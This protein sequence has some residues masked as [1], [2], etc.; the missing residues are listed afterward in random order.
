MTFWTFAFISLARPNQTLK[1]L[2]YL[3]FEQVNFWFCCISAPEAL[4][5]F[6]ACGLTTPSED[7]SE[8]LII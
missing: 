5:F 4:P 8:Y 3:Y 6:N 7:I 1:L 2:N